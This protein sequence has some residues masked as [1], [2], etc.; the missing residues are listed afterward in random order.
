MAHK[1]KSLTPETSN[2]TDLIFFFFWQRYISFTEFLSLLPN[3][4]DL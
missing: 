2:V 3:I 1:K 4:Y